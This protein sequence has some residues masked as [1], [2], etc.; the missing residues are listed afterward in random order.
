MTEEQLDHSKW[1]PV[2]NPH[3]PLAGINSVELPGYRVQALQGQLNRFGA[4]YFQLLLSPGNG[5]GE[6]ELF[7][8]GLYHRGRYPAQNWFEIIYIAPA[9]TFKS[10]SEV[11]LGIYSPV[12]LQVFKAMVDALP[13]GG[14]IMVEYDSPAQAETARALVAGIPPVAT[15]TGYVLFMAGCRAGFKDW[16]FAEGGSEGPRKLQ[17]YKPLNSQHL[18]DKAAVIESELEEFLTSSENQ[19]AK[20]STDSTLNRAKE[21]LAVLHNIIQQT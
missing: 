7:I 1:Q 9:V 13:P 3:S 16:Y 20:E 11:A 18:R 5:Q 19:Q 8:T 6:A 10:G 4:R 14:H 2:A 17:A 12:T 21:V 15:P